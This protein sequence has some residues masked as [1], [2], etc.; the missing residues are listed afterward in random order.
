[1]PKLFKIALFAAALALS[2]AAIAISS[3]ATTT[4]FAADRPDSG[5]LLRESAPPPTLRPQQLLPKIEPQQP[6]KEA[7]T[8]GVRVRVS[9]FT[10]TGNTVFSGKELA[11]LM[12]GYIGKELTLAELNTAAATIT[13]AY[14]AKGYFLASANIPPQTIKS[15][16]PI[17]IEII[18]GV[19]EEVRQTGATP[20]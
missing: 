9:G 7:E 14:R 20:R 15:E 5:S 13:N 4:A 12:S 1:M 10:F 18:E 19:L 3:A 8:S 17:V 16:A 11:A 2:A 6:Q